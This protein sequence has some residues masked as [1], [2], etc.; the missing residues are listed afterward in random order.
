MT[1]L[2]IKGH[3]T[4]GKEVI[5]ILEK[6][7]GKNLHHYNGDNE[8]LCYYI[9]NCIGTKMITYDL[10]ESTFEEGYQKPLVLTLEEF[11]EKYSNKIF[12]S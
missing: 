11:L 7:G 5:E 12:S 10:I 9:F 3:A 2:A 6:L 4:R 1:N 8:S